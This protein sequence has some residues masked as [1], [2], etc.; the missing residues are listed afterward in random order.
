MELLS[1]V[2][3]HDPAPETLEGKVL[4]SLVDWIMDYEKKEIRKE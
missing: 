3:E 2:M 4:L 1:R